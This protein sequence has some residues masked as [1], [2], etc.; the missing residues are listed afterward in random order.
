MIGMSI[1]GSCLI[2]L[3]ESQMIYT[4]SSVQSVSI[5]SVLTLK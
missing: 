1:K 2:D 4:Y 5:V 3:D